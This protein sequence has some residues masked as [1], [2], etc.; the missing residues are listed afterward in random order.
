MDRA[1]ILASSREKSA[2]LEASFR[3]NPLRDKEGFF[4]HFW[5]RYGPAPL[6][7]NI[8]PEVGFQMIEKVSP[9]GQGAVLPIDEMD[10]ENV[11]YG[12]TKNISYAQTCRILEE[13]LRLS[14]GSSPEGRIRLGRYV[15]GT[16]QW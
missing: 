4:S 9:D 15:A 8:V 7:L 2:Y 16:L 13:I 1:A 14:F 5:N 11:L 10:V 3:A 6:L 12:V